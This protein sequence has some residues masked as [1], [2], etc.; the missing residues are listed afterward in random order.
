MGILLCV[1]VSGGGLLARS[2]HLPFKPLPAA[3]K[4]EP[5]DEPSRLR[6]DEQPRETH[7]SQQ[8]APVDQ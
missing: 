3:I 4:A 7:E 2:I 1:V 6:L 8:A 5:D